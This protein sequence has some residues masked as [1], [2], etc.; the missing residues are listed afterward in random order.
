MELCITN[1]LRQEKGPV[2]LI[3]PLLNYVT[4]AS[5]WL[6]LGFTRLPTPLTPAIFFT[7]NQPSYTTSPD[8]PCWFPI[9]NQPCCFSIY[10]Q[11]HQLLYPTTPTNLDTPPYSPTVI[12]DNPPVVVIPRCPYYRRLWALWF[13][14][15]FLLFCPFRRH[16]HRLLPLSAGDKLQG[17]FLLRL[18]SPRKSAPALL[19]Q[20]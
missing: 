11:P 18:S 4:W 14:G 6:A 8:Q 3:G 9:C 10:D 7:S 16:H 13:S 5:F 15:S 1:K 12:Y 2:V 19:G 20:C 17:Q